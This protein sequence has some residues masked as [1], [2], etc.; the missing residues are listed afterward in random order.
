MIYGVAKMAQFIGT[1]VRSCLYKIFYVHPVFWL[2][3]CL[4]VTAVNVVMADDAAEVA[5]PALGTPA[6]TPAEDSP[7]Q[8][9]TNIPSQTDDAS[10]TQTLPQQSPSQPQTFR[11]QPQ[12]D[13][14][15]LPAIESDSQTSSGNVV[16]SSID[17]THQVI[18]DS[19]LKL[20]KTIDEYFSNERIIEEMK[21][22]YGCLKTSVL[23][24]QGGESDITRTACLKMDLPNTRKRWKLFIEG[25]NKAEEINNPGSPLAT[26][27]TGVPEENTGSVAG[28]SYV[29]KA[30]KKRYLSSDIGVRSRL[31]L[32]PF[33]RLRFRRTWTPGN[34]LYR[35]TESL[36]YYKSIE[37]GLLSRVD[38]ERP[39]SSSWYTRITTQADYR[40]Q[41]SEFYWKQTFGLYR[42]VKKGHALSW[43]FILSGGT[44]PNARM[45]YF[46]YRFRYRINVWRDWLFFEASPQLL[47]KSEDNFRQVAGILF[48]IEAEFGSY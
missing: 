27:E 40:D 38:F 17:S 48:A 31:P 13:E 14:E 19:I 35:I 24:Q 3:L 7:E 4:Y 44:Q 28:I 6:K 22:T 26:T 23:F 37:G 1:A 29:A 32:D 15:S 30:E 47:H 41:D 9:A 34:W 21:G 18:S 10:D 20:S 8:P 42:Q 2:A 11:Q 45:D 16:L 25:N 39:V 33:W 36:Y 43:E 12:S 5:Q 46:L